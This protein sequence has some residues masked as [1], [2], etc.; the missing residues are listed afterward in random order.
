MNNSDLRRKYGERAFEVGL[1]L[2]HQTFE[3]RGAQ[4]DRLD[5]HFTRLWLDYAI[6]G[7]G[8]RPVLDSRTRYL[9]LT[10]QFTMGKSLP[11]L[12]DTVRGA[13]A[14]GVKPREILETILQC[15]I[16]GGHT[17]ADP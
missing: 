11:A 14:A 7:L 4:R 3:R 1:A 5:Q 12:D 9:V 15:R 13:L 2:Q 16:Y 10:G 17:T 8:E 6:V